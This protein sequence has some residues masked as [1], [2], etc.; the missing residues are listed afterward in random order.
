MAIAAAAHAPSAHVEPGRALRLAL[1][2]D[3]RD[4]ATLLEEILGESSDRPL[5]I[6]HYERLGDA[7]PRMHAGNVDCVLLDLSLSDA[8]HLDG[9]KELVARDSELPVVVITGNEDEQLALEALNAGAQDYIRKRDVDGEIVHRAIRY[10]MERKRNELELAHSA[11]H[12][13]L[14]GLPNRALFR[15][16]LELAL[17]RMR[18]EPSAIAVMFLDLD[19]FKFVNDSLGHQAGDEL[20]T[21]V[22][23]RL[24]G[25]MRPGDTVARFGGDEFLVL[26]GELDDETQAM[27]L[28]Q[29]L[30]DGICAPVAVRGQDVY[31]GASIGVAYTGQAEADPERL[32]SDADEAMYRAKRAGSGIELAD[33]L[34]SAAAAKRLRVDTELRRAIERDELELHY[35]PQFDYGRGEIVALEALLRWQHPLRGLLPAGEFLPAMEQTG[36]LDPLGTRLIGEAC[37]QLAYWRM[38]GMGPPDLRV[39]VNLSLRQ[40]ACPEIQPGIEAALAE[41]DLPPDALCIEITEA[42]VAAEP[43][44][45]VEQV[46]AITGLGVGLA[47]DDFGT[48][49][50]SLSALD[51]FPLDIVKIDG[52]FTS[53]LG[54]GNDTALEVFRAMLGVPRAM[55]LGVVAEG[56]ETR[57]QFAE[58]A[59]AGCQAAQGR[60]LWGPVPAASVADV[61]VERPPTPHR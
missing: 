58:V 37:A 8:R 13:E 44:A 39:N 59:E 29:R 15:D 48:G 42:A 1:I 5:V 18:R 61:L 19:H 12:D 27:A 43:A 22:G 11:L 57:V 46:S 35:Q 6:A 50:S 33:G 23:I 38:E 34:G 21:A 53:K 52:S 17:A 7:L 9:V 60:F 14:T 16:R 40:L 31:V 36:L 41:H 26:C 55:G 32:I 28:G 47:L 10:A 20:L 49:L 56:V 45:V 24:V 51:G 54:L 4:Y 25:L 2:E 30:H 3:S